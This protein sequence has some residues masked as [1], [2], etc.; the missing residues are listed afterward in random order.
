M[1]PPTPISVIVN[2]DCPNLEAKV[3]QYEWDYDSDIDA[4]FGIEFESCE[5]VDTMGDEECDLPTI[6]CKANLKNGQLK[7]WQSSDPADNGIIFY[8]S[9]VSA[10][11]SYK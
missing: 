4:E 2:Y 9:E 1:Y 3:Y 5:Y 7:M 8:E 10:K 11:S 6:M